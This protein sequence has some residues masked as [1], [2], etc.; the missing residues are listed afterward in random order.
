MDMWSPSQPRH[1]TH[2]EK[3]LVAIK[4]WIEPKASLNNFKLHKRQ[5][6]SIQNLSASRGGIPKSKW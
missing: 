6:N 4:A 3:T 5:Q 2:G 1:F